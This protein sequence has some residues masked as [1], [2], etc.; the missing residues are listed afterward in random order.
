MLCYNCIFSSC[1]DYYK[2]YRQSYAP[3][4]YSV[5]LVG[6]NKT[7]EEEKYKEDL[8]KAQEK[9]GSYKYLF[10]DSPFYE[11][12]IAMNTAGSR[13][14]VFLNPEKALE[15]SYIDYKDAYDYVSRRFYIRRPKKGDLESFRTFANR[16][17]QIDRGD[18]AE[19][20][21]KCMYLGHLLYAYRSS[22]MKAETE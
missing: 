11:G 3:I 15:Q 20:E 16:C 7:L 14:L 5:I 18:N 4:D 8:A 17:D 10:G 9:F 13:V 6:A 1:Y 19:L 12:S 21:L 22:Y 2:K